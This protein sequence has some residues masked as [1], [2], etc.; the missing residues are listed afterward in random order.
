MN[1]IMLIYINECNFDKTENIY[2]TG[3]CLIDDRLK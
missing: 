1:I 3:N 2:S